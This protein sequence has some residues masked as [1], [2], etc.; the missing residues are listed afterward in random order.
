[1]N[2][3]DLTEIPTILV[4]NKSDRMNRIQV[5]QTA[6]R[7]NGIAISALYE[8]GLSRLREEMGDIIF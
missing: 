4:L 6:K 8:A 2:G 7:L 1:L 3:L 5:A